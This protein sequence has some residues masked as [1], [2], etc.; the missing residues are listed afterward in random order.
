[1]SRREVD[2][3]PFRLVDMNVDNLYTELDDFYDTAEAEPIPS[4]AESEVDIFD[5]EEEMPP[6]NGN[7]MPISDS[8]DE[9]DIPLFELKARLTN[10]LPHNAPLLN[11]IYNPPK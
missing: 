3:L 10:N 2:E 5:V 4:D 9:V 6:D 11:P 7:D 8:E 1:M